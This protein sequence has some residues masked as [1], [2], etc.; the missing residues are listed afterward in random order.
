MPTEPGAR[1]PRIE[2]LRV[3]N[4][5]ALRDVELK[6]LTPLTV[7]LGPN[8]SG[9]STVFDVLAFLSECFDTGLRPAWERRNRFRELRTRG[10]DGPITFEIRY[11]E[12]P[13]APLMTYHLEVDEVG[14]SPVVRRE[15]LH[16][17]RGSHGRPFR[18][19]DFEQGRGNVVGGERPDDEARRSPEE[20]S[21][22]ELLAVSTLGRFSRHPRVAALRD[23]VSGWY[24]SYISA[25]GA[26]GIPEAGPQERLSVTGDN[27]PNV[28]QYLDEQHPERLEKILRILGTRVPRLERV[29]SR[30][31]EDGR[32]ML[33]IKDAPFSEPVL[34]K[35]ASDGTIKLL[36]YLTVLHD[37]E[38]APF[39]GIEEPENRLFPSL[40]AGLA[41]E[42]REAAARSQVF[43]T[44]HSPS[45]VSAVR[46]EELRILER[47]GRGFTRIVPVTDLQQ[48]MNQVRAGATLGDL[49]LE[50]YFY[51]PSGTV[52]THG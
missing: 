23:F 36:A 41:E 45:F 21:S 42:C 13:G 43:V 30:V 26:R 38:P 29:V 18:F 46:P 15:W 2:S 31:L 12:E 37:P 49:W 27:L 39:I 6:K 24:L 50:R 14:R 32:L 33:Q 5:R 34:A 22:P 25:A 44:T 11:R 10:C 4:Y 17:R 47:D 19:L 52:E 3:T 28:I 9:K 40:M 35:F 7:F 1:I 8:G 48:V 51:T 20:L 16:W